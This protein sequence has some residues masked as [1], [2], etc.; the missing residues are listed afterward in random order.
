MNS[1]SFFSL[2]R[3]IKSCAFISTNIC[4]CDVVDVYMTIK[5]YSKQ[6]YHY[7][8][9]KTSSVSPPPSPYNHMT[10]YKISESKSKN[11]IKSTASF[12]FSDNCNYEIC[13]I[14]LSNVLHEE[15]DIRR[16]KLYNLQLNELT[17]SGILTMDLRQITDENGTYILLSI[18]YFNL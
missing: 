13:L 14:K 16:E 11:A 4:W 6:L 3:L 5:V 15:F 1:F 7:I 2:F 9:N 8:N 12:F 18:F 10:G 17:I